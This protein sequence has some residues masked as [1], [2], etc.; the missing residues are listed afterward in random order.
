MNNNQTKLPRNALC[1]LYKSTL[2]PVIEY[3]DIIFDNCTVRAALAIENVQRRDALAYV[4]VHISTPALIVKLL[5]LNWIPL[6]QRR[7]T[8][9]LVMLC[10]IIHRLAPSYLTAIL[11]RPRD[12]GYRLRSFDN[13]SLPTPSARLSCVR[14]YFLSSSI[15]SW[16]S[17]DE[18]IRSSS[19][20]LS[21]K[22]KLKRHKCTSHFNPT[23]YS[24]FLG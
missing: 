5:E 13:M 18:I 10:K 12:A 4:Q 3:Y 17:L 11:P 8:H 19:S 24:R 23:L 6:R 1:A 16:N 7:T 2:L 20:Y 9:K 22:S 14:N 15:L 21:F